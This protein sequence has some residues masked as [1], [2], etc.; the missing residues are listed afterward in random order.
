MISILCR[1]LS[2]LSVTAETYIVESLKKQVLNALLGCLLAK[3][4][5]VP[6]ACCWLLTIHRFIQSPP[7]IDFYLRPSTLISIIVPSKI[8]TQGEK[9]SAF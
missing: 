7:L 3:E 8:K 6:K 4:F 1:V 9:V 5:R 2:R